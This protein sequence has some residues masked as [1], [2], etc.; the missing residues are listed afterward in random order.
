[1]QCHAIQLE[2]ETIRH[3]HLTVWDWR[4]LL[5][6][7]SFTCHTVNYNLLQYISSTTNT[8]SACH[9]IIRDITDIVKSP[10]SFHTEDRSQSLQSG[11]NSFP[12][13]S[14]PKYRDLSI[15]FHHSPQPTPPRHYFHLKAY[16]S[17]HFTK[18][19]LPTWWLQHMLK[20]NKFN[21]N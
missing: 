8:H 4:L 13:L 7:S 15:K 21:M 12:L 10:F 6:Y 11:L 18:F 5:Y 14:L 3:V 1:V 9:C 20:H 2:W 19:T 16:V 17:N